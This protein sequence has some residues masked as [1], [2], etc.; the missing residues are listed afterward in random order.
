MENKKF[1]F[2]SLNPFIEQDII[3][4]KESK[5]SG[6]EY[7]LWGD[8]NRYPS[9]LTELYN[10]VTTLASVING[11]VDYAVGDDTECSAGLIEGKYLNWKKET[12]RDI[13]RKLA[14]NYYRFGGWAIQVIRN[15][16]GGIA[17]IYSV[18]MDNLRTDKENEVFWY[19]EEWDKRSGSIK[20]V[21][22]P[23]FV[24]EFREPVSILYYKGASTGTYPVPIY[25]PA[26]RACEIE[27]SIDEFHL[28]EINN[29]FM[30]SYVFNFNNGVPEDEVKDEIERD[31]NEKFAGKSNAG[32][33][34][35]SWNESKE[36]ALTLEK[37]D[38]SDYGDKYSTLS[39][40]CRQ[41]IFSAF[42]ANANLFGIPTE[43]NGFNAEEYESSFKL[44]SRVA[45]K[46][47]QM[48]IVDCFEKIYGMAC[49][50]IKPF[51]LDGATTNA[52]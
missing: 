40:H 51:T 23:K 12:P 32:R 18:D 31:I 35:L 28:N 49:L 14:N 48:A 39:K 29:G 43:S 22:Y 3:S 24:S 26:V 33:I 50:T 2:L 15:M 38:I 7:I 30:G 13:V 41:Q 16:E 34:M 4:P 37:L 6:K 27:R 19:S 44:Y 8:S 5:V 25:T 10:S 45:V 47:V 36:N 9:Y 20:A 11:S 17:E 52:E 46:P 1:A 42:R 21:Q